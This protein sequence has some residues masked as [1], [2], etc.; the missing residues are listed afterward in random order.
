MHG[1]VREGLRA[2]GMKEGWSFVGPGEALPQRG[3]ARGFSELNN[4]ISGI[5]L[6]LAI[7][8][9]ESSFFPSCLFT[10]LSLWVET[11]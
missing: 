1:K 7:C 2:T 10:P 9:G 8:T 4:S 5:S 6:N 3:T 11:R